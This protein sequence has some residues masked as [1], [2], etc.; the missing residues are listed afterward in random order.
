[1]AVRADE[2]ELGALE[3]V[4]LRPGRR[5][6]CNA[7]A[8]ELVGVEQQGAAARADEAGGEVDVRD[9]HLGEGDGWGWGWG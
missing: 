8:R 6:A 3:L 4:E 1:M 9:A 2:P 5:G 7:M